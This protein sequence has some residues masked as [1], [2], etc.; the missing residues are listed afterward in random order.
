MLYITI[1]FCVRTFYCFNASNY[2]VVSGVNSVKPCLSHFKNVIYGAVRMHIYTEAVVK[3]HSNIYGF[4]MSPRCF[5]KPS[6]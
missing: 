2:G 1:L 3:D 4:L 5:I 6:M